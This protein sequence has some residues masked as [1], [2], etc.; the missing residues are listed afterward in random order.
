MSSA[1][2]TVP[3]LPGMSDGGYEKVRNLFNFTFSNMSKI[4]KVSLGYPGWKMPSG[5]SDELEE[6][7]LICIGTALL[8]CCYCLHLS[9]SANQ[10]FRF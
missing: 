9:L 2:L 5:V 8:S 1:S 3:R 7:G 4:R 6:L 10:V